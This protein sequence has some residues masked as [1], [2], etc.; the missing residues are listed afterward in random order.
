MAT[1]SFDRL[2]RE[3]LAALEERTSDIREAFGLGT[4]VASTASGI[5]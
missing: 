4:P 2:A 5:P 1:V 3:G